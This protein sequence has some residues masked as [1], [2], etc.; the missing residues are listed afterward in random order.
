MSWSLARKFDQMESDENRKRR[1]ISN[2]LDQHTAIESSQFIQRR[3]T[4]S[5]AVQQHAFHRETK[6]QIEI[7]GLKTHNHGLIESNENLRFV[8]TPLALKNQGSKMKHR[9]ELS[10][11]QDKTRREKELKA[12]LKESNKELKS[13]LNRV[14]IALILA[15]VIIVGLFASYKIQPQLLSGRHFMMD[16]EKSNSSL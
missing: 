13:K 6:K 16:G 4:L 7:V 8:N 5:T 3:S 14:Q 10:K 12:Q 11:E 2:Y 9:L 15:C 1:T